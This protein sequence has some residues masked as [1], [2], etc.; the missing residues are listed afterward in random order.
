MSSGAGQ[1]NDPYRDIVR[2]YDAEHDAFTEDIALY[3]QLA[4]VVGDPILE[5][6]CGTGRIM[7]PLLAAGHRVTGLDSSPPMLAAARQRLSQYLRSGRATLVMASMADAGSTP[8]AH[9]GLVILALNGLL[10]A[11]SQ[12]SQRAVLTQARAALDP[13]GMVVIDTPNPHVELLR[14]DDRVVLLE[15]QWGVDGNTVQKH[16]SRTLDRAEQLIGATLAYDLVSVSGEIRRTV[17]SF[18]QR[19]LWPSELLLLLELAGFVECQVYGSY[20]LDP[21]TSDSERLI[22]TAEASPSAR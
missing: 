22:V 21:Y 6:A 2:W 8:S 14:I 12:D 11:E 17:T 13:R 19:F 10:H 5:L 20:D 1:M 18:N 15:G 9:F 4:E 7:Q 16:S 3:L